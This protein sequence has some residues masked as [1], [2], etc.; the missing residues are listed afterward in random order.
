MKLSIV[1]FIKPRKYLKLK[2]DSLFFGKGKK[3]KIAKDRKTR[4][5]LS[6]SQFF[7]N[8]PFPFFGKGVSWQLLKPRHHLCFWHHCHYPTL[9]STNVIQVWSWKMAKVRRFYGIS[10]KITAASVLIKAFPLVSS[11]RWELRLR[12]SLTRHIVLTTICFSISRVV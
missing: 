5:N 12:L 1:F 9:C 10:L 6:H 8:N 4:H 2:A 11:F 3:G 7:L